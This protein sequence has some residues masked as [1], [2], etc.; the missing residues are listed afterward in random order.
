MNQIKRFRE[1]PGQTTINWFHTFRRKPSFMGFSLF[2]VA[3]ILNTIVRGP[4][5]FFNVNTMNTLF[6][7]QMPFLLLVLAQGVLLI[8]G[9]LD[10][11][12]G[13]QIGLVNVVTIMTIQEWGVPF[14]VG[15]IFGI[16]IA[17]VASI[18]CWL[19]VSVWRLPTLLASFALIS[20]ILG[21]NVLIMDVPQGRLP[22][23]IFHMYNNV[24]FGW[25]PAA[26]FAIV[27]VMVIWLFIK[28][29]PFGTNIYAVGANPQN[30]YAAGISP[31]KVQFQAFM[32]KGFITGVAGICL[33][34]NAL[35]GNPLQ[36]EALG[37]RSLA[38][39]IVG[40]LTF[41]GWGT[42]S[43]ALFGGSFMIL[44][45]S[46]MHPLFSR[47]MEM[48]PGLTLGTYWHNMVSDTIIFLGL[49]LSIVTIKGQREALRISI[50]DKYSSRRREE[51]AK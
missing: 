28:R 14:I 20:V 45:Q 23:E 5:E 6:V 50:R 33:T 13:I 30:A 43:S 2:L 32:F 37:L 4:G 29:T 41:G 9:T 49:L 19:L 17:M 12:I 42:M 24:H 11:S 39:C 8:S 46:M 31:V 40:G 21:V 10:V 36:G 16:L 22:M 48:F 25:L 47:L 1:E 51:H 26:S 3:I 38:A 34:M 15:A 7:T 18:V 35:S 44:I 27:L